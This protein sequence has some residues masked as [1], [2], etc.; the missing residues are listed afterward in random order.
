MRLDLD[1]RHQRS[2]MVVVGVI[3]PNLVGTISADDFASGDDGR[4]WRLGSEEGD[5]KMGFSSKKHRR[6][7]LEGKAGGG[8]SLSLGR[9][10]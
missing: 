3:R 5:D 9:L 2:S 4:A 1:E 6:L 8:D 7:T 10:V